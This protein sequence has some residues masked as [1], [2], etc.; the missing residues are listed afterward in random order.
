MSKFRLSN[1]RSS[2][3]VSL[4][5]RHR[6][7]IATGAL[8]SDGVPAASNMRKVTWDDELANLAELWASQCVSIIETNRKA[9]LGGEEVAV[10]FIK[11]I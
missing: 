6:R 4:N 1:Y 11:F 9:L 3:L 5:T 8:V 10:S 2:S 7:S